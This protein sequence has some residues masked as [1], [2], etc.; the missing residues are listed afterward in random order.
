[1]M[2]TVD[3]F[4]SLH[5]KVK[6]VKLEIVLSAYSPIL[7]RRHNIRT[8]MFFVDIARLILFRPRFD[9]N[10]SQQCKFFIN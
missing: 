6:C 8:D 3:D 1:M 7:A 5:N 4:S 9:F 10:F 2:M